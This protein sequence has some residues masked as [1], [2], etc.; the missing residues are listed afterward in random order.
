MSYLLKNVLEYLVSSID[1]EVLPTSIQKWSIELAQYRVG[2]IF[3]KKESFKVCYKTTTV[4]SVQWLKFRILH[5]I[6]PVGYYLRIV[7]VIIKSLD[8]C[9]FCEKNVEFI[10]HI[11]TTCDKIHTLW[12]VYRKYL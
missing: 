12:N 2:N 1:K 3:L 5:S 10:V 4:S 11:F 6:L 7:N 8:N 9:G